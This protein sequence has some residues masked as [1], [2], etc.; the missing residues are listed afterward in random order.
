VAAVLAFDTGK[1]VVQIAAVKVTVNHLLDIRPPEAVLLG[2]VLII[3][4]N[5]SLK[6]ILDA[7]IIIRILRTAGMV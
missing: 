7:M 2:E 3:R 6:I 1:T 5:E 4:M